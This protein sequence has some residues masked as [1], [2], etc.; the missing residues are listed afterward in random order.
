MIR[1][2][3]LTAYLILGAIVLLS[4]PAWFFPAEG[5]TRYT[6]TRVPVETGD[7]GLAYDP[8]D[9]HGSNRHLND[10]E[11]IGCDFTDEISLSRAC[12]FDRYLLEQGP[13]TVEGEDEGGADP[14]FVYLKGSYY[15]RL[16]SPVSDG[17]RY[18]V[19]RAS[20]DRVLDEL[21]RD[22]SSLPSNP[23]YEPW[24]VGLIRRGGTVRSAAP[25]QDHVL[26]RIY[27]AHGGYY[28]VALVEAA[29]LDRPFVSPF[30]RV[31]LGLAGVGLLAL[32]GHRIWA[33]RREA[34]AA[35]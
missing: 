18:D 2:R 4:N 29:P 27:Q 25:P 17:Y 21:A 6:Y 9:N 19:E 10:L 14:P 26:G 31:L 3:L 16:E 12:T 13:V 1:S 33:A 15:E 28:A 34:P 35:N 5:E 7:D 24:D 23:E 8:P 32:A 20:P 30:V 22:A 11:G